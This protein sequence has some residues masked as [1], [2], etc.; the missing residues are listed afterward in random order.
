MEIIHKLSS[1]K[2]SIVLLA[3]MIVLLIPITVNTHL[4]YATDAT[5]LSWQVTENDITIISPTFEIHIAKTGGISSYLFA[6]M[7]VRNIGLLIHPYKGGWY[8]TTTYGS[9]L[10]DPVVEQF[11]GGVKV[12]TFARWDNPEY[13]MHFDVTME[14]YVY[15]TGAVMVSVLIQTWQDTPSIQYAFKIF[16]ISPDV[17]KGATVEGYYGGSLS[18]S[19]TIPEQKKWQIGKG[20]TQVLIITQRA[21][22]VVYVNLDPLVNLVINWPSAIEVKTNFV[23]EFPVYKGDELKL[24]FLFW[25][26]DRGEDFNKKMIALFT[27]LSE[28]MAMIEQGKAAFSIPMARRNLVEAEEAIPEALNA[29]AMADLSRAEEL[30]SNVYNLARRG[31]LTEVRTRASIYIVIPLAI[32]IVLLVWAKIKWTGRLIGTK[33]KS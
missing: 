10:K 12:V 5:E 15:E 29:I 27:K 26:H 21:I 18:F 25:M 33:T 30:I 32:C 6:D 24:V 19:S 22:S 16:Q 20:Y 4:T 2:L 31:Y 17:F 14:H 23:S 8:F 3:V 9:I 1:F 13:D 7:E 11:E 28:A